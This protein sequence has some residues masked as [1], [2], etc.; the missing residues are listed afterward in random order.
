MFYVLQ[1]PNFTAFDYAV[2]MC[3]SDGCIRNSQ[4]YSWLMYGK[5]P[6]SETVY[7]SYALQ[8]VVADARNRYLSDVTVI[9]IPVT[10]SATTLAVGDTFTINNSLIGGA[11]TDNA[12]I[13][14]VSVLG[15]TATITGVAAGNAS[16][17]ITDKANDPAYIVSVTVA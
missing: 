12:S 11:T 2:R 1:Y 6:E 13:A 8:N 15:T 14:S 17:T 16:I 9:P 4:I 3:D 5:L 10:N 7:P